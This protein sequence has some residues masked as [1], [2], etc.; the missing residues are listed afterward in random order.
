MCVYL[1]S[2][3]DLKEVMSHQKLY[4]HSMSHNVDITLYEKEVN[5][6]N[7]SMVKAK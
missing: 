1:F 2:R 3:P 5:R 4:K 6:W 7:L